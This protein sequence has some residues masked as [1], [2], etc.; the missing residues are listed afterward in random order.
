[1]LP[2]IPA[3]DVKQALIIQL[4]DNKPNPTKLQ[5][6]KQFGKLT[7]EQYLEFKACFVKFKC[8]TFDANQLLEEERNYILTMLE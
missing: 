4:V 3:F 7:L 5:L 1:M 6:S 8:I 2:K